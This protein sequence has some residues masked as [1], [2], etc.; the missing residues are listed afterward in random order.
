MTLKPSATTYN[1]ITTI[2]ERKNRKSK[3]K[4]KH[5]RYCWDAPK[6]KDLANS[7]ITRA[8]SVV[9]MAL[10]TAMA[11]DSRPLGALMRNNC[12]GY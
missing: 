2:Y 10:I 11:A 3:V 6:S 9:G 12:D 1:P 8:T 7:A 4:M 5:Q